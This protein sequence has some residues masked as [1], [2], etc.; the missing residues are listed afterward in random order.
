MRLMLDD[1]AFASFETLEQ[2]LRQNDGHAMN[3]WGDSFEAIVRAALND[4][5]DKPRVESVFLAYVYG[6][7][8]MS[9]PL[10]DPE[11]LQEL[12]RVDFQTAAIIE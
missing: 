10:L 4:T 12:E 9:D 5:V 1:G 3:L 2:W 7:G 8:F 11:F 6:T